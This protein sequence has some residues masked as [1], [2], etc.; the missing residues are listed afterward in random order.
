MNF[1]ESTG[2]L[3]KCSSIRLSVYQFLVSVYQFLVSVFSE[4]III[5]PINGLGDTFHFE[6]IVFD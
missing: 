6:L 3:R 1:N 2:I 5:E 4:M